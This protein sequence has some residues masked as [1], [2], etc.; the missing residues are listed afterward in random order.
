MGQKG[1]AMNNNSKN[2][3]AGQ[4]GAIAAAGV[5]FE[6]AT[7]FFGRAPVGAAQSAFLGYLPVLFCVFL[8][9]QVVRRAVKNGPGK[10]MATV[11]LCVYF[12]FCAA[13]TAA[14]AVSFFVAA[15]G[16]ARGA[17]LF[18]F[19]FCAVALYG[20]YLG[21][22][23]LGRSALPVCFLT[24]GLLFF[25]VAI[26]TAPEMATRNLVFAPVGGSAVSAFCKSHL[27]SPGLYIA[28]LVFYEREEG[29]KKTPLK[30]VLALQYFVLCGLAFCGQLVMGRFMGQTKQPVLFLLQAGSFFGQLN[31]GTFCTA[32]VFMCG[33]L[34]V[35]FLGYSCAVLLGRCFPKV[36]TRPLG[37][38]GGVALMCG[39]LAV[40]FLNKSVALRSGVLL[41]A[42]LPLAAALWL[43]RL[44]GGEKKEG[45]R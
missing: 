10:N 36:Q 7:A 9:A 43:A 17:G 4:L 6:S 14:L 12:I 11:C 25:G 5:L 21:P 15:G 33:V 32:A 24:G 2:N 8:A 3:M 38:Y 26:A 31:L 19:L 20:A 13:N 28:C 42:V 27:L 22:G 29:K 23:A 18:C 44:T 37:L 45:K 16:Q 34:E 41:I 1:A 39:V 30:G 35:A 40:W